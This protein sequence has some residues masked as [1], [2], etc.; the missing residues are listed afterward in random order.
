[1]RTALRTGGRRGL[2]ACVCALG[3]LGLIAAGA[4]RGQ[5][6]G[7]GAVVSPAAAAPA[8][9]AGGLDMDINP[10]VPASARQSGGLDMDVNP[11]APL[12]VSPTAPPALRD[13]VQD[14]ISPGNPP[15][16]ADRTPSLLTLSP[17]SG[18]MPGAVTGQ[19]VM[20]EPVSLDRPTVVDTA[21]F[22]AGSTIVALYG[23]EGVKGEMAQG[24]QGFLTSHGN[25]MTC[26]AQLSADFVCLQSDGT[27]VAEVALVNGAARTRADAPAPY[28]DQEAAAQAARRGIWANLPAPPVAVKHPAVPDTATLVADGQA[29]VLDG[30]QGVGA[31]FSGQLQD[32]IAQHGDSLT[33][34]PQTV[35]GH[36]VCLL[37]DGTDIAKIALING[38]A[39]VA[40]DAPD[41]YRVQQAEALNNHRGFWLNQS[42]E[43]IL[44]STAVMQP[45]ECCAFV[46]G[47][48]GVD[49]I[50][51]IGGV[52]T[53][54]IEGETVFL[55]YG[56]DAGWGYYD[57]W[58]HWRG[59]PDRYRSHLERYHP[60]GHGLRGYGHEG[61]MHREA[62]MHY[63]GIH[64][65][66][67]GPGEHPGMGGPGMHPGMAGAGMHP[68]MAGPGMHPGV[69]GPGMH[70]G[71]A[72]PGMHPGMAGPGMHPG[73]PGGGFIHPGPSAAGFHPG[74]AAPA[75]HATPAVHASSGGGGGGKKH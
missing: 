75:M 57:H 32:Y 13:T 45:A 28:R 60:D 46:E 40:P 4:A 26:Q 56:G 20:P 49:G 19:P 67:A 68:G 3:A 52:P 29:Y 21:T 1:M 5:T 70:P 2:M 63:G 74:G 7:S 30:L 35:P 14:T 9:Q 47:D 11:T 17:N 16:A 8:S 41:S 22:Q 71:M 31:P 10:A 6:A 65:G 44:A 18:Q 62:A 37:G 72:A 58:H 48:D 69:A 38:A 15:P 12:V 36:Y 39:R 55:T 42:Q 27:D 51:Y 64:Q 24:L 25:H 53:A 54:M 59:A 66:M 73:G 61:A 34:D 33:C 50:A 43:V 23:I